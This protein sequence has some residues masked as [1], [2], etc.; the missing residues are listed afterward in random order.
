MKMPFLLHFV[1]LTRLDLA[2]VKAAMPGVKVSQLHFLL[3]QLRLRDRVEV[4][5][6]LQLKS[7]AVWP[8]WC[9][10][11]VIANKGSSLF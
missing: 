9:A 11:A 2:I 7:V 5:P 8:S 6:I 1:F 10:V 4:V 3:L